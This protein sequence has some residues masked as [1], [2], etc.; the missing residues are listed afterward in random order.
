MRSFAILS[1]SD[2]GQN[3]NFVSFKVL[4][5]NSRPHGRQGEGRPQHQLKMAGDGLVAKKSSKNDKYKVLWVEGRWKSNPNFIP[6]LLQKGFQVDRVSSG[7]EALSN[8]AKKRHDIVVVDAAS[9][10]TSGKRICRSLRDQANGMPI[11]LISDPKRAVEKDYD[12]ANAILTL[13]F[14][15]RKLI[16]RI[17]P[18]LPSDEKGL[19][20]AGAIQLDTEE[21]YVRANGKKTALTPRLVQLLKMLVDHKG[22]VVERD[23]L[24]KKVWRTEYTG[25]TRTLDV[26][27]SWL[28][29][30]I[31]KNPKRPKL[32]KTMRG[33]GYRLDV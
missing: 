8:V 18:L 24:F 28:R 23:T 31:E 5:Y 11:M 14:T 21:K 25:D 29:R 12:C 9:M 19:I 16:N 15:Q 17:G 22:E 20:K 3:M 26:H 7:K 1:Q 30:A 27:I 4:R 2:G 13:P 10:R 33:V 32:L 6:S